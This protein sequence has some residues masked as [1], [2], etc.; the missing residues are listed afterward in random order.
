MGEY[1]RQVLYFMYHNC[2]KYV[3]SRTLWRCASVIFVASFFICMIR[4]WDFSFQYPDKDT[5]PFNNLWTCHWYLNVHRLSIESVLLLTFLIIHFPRLSI[6]RTSTITRTSTLHHVFDSTER[7]TRQKPVT[8]WRPGE[9]R[10]PG[11]RTYN[12][13][14]ASS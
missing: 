11:S 9:D 14:T 2:I 12:S 8:V 3:T 6:F 7:D 4:E 1:S 5:V 13:S 10:G